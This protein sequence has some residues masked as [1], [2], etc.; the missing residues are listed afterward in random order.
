[1]EPLSRELN[2]PHCLGASTF[3]LAT[4]NLETGANY[5]VDG[6]EIREKA[7]SSREEH[8]QIHMESFAPLPAKKK[9]KNTG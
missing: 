3:S 6:D 4:P 7:L 9:P 5:E 1:M 8:E 2:G